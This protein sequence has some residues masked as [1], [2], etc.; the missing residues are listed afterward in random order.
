VTEVDDVLK[1]LQDWLQP[2]RRLELEQS[3]STL[4]PYG[5]ALVLQC[6]AETARL[7]TNAVS[8]QLSTYC[9]GSMPYVAILIDFQGCEYRF[10]SADLGRVLSYIAAW[11]RGW[12]AP[13]AIVLPAH[14][15]GEL[16][17]LLALVKVDTLDALAIVATP[18]LGWLHLRSK[19]GDCGPTS[20]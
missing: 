13:C 16:R 3:V 2:A 17:R 15:A 10:S 5:E 19:L 20:A 8:A 1:R 9:D 12:V 11:K 4:A 14:S 7:P 6:P 18:E